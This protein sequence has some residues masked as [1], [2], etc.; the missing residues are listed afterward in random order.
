MNRILL[1]AGSWAWITIVHRWAA[2]LY[3]QS[4]DAKAWKSIK[5]QYV[6]FAMFFIHKFITDI[7]LGYWIAPAKPRQH[8][9]YFVIVLFLLALLLAVF[10]IIHSICINR[11]VILKNLVCKCLVSGN[12]D[13]Q[14][15]K[16]E[17]SQLDTM[18]KDTS[19]GNA[20]L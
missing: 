4:F 5:F 19:I 6:T 17:N 8:A 1:V 14:F 15:I 18:E 3:D 10:C 12:R 9:I 16:R 7:L 13:V 2:T 11:Q 20:T